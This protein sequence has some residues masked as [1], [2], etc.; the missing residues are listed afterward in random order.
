MEICEGKEKLKGARDIG[1]G[2]GVVWIEKEPLKFVNVISNGMASVSSRVSF[3]SCRFEDEVTV[4]CPV[5]KGEMLF[6]RSGSF[7]FSESTDF[8]NLT[9]GSYAL[10]A[11][12]NNASVCNSST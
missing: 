1:E 4:D 5:Y 11:E 2:E 3:S 8:S 7:L 6:E 12:A 10:E 9:T